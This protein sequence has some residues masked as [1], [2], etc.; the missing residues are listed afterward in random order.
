MNEN[1]TTS[2]RSIVRNGIYSFS[3][4]FLPLALSFFATPIIVRLLGNEDYGIYALILGFI[5][6]SFNF[7]VGR[8]ITKY[9]AEYR[10]GDRN[11]EIGDVIASTFFINIALGLFGLILITLSANFLVDD[12]L[13]IQP[14]N[15]DKTVYALYIASL[16]IF[17][18][19]LNQVFSAIL[20][21]LLR[22][23]VYAKIFNLN[24]ILLISG[25]IALALKGFGLLS[26]LTWNLSVT[27][28]SS[29]LSFI[30][31]KK[32]LPQ[33]TLRIG[34]SR[35]KLKLVFRFS[36]GVI[37]Y[38]ILANILLLFERSWITGKLGAENLTLYVVPMML[39]LYIHG[40]ISSLTMMLIPLASELGGENEKLLRLYKKATKIVCFFAFFI[41]ST[42]IVESRS[43]LTLWMG[44]DFADKSAQLLILHTITFSLLAITIVAWQL[45]EGLGYPKINTLFFVICFIVSVT[46]MIVLLPDFGSFG[47]AL[48][49][50]LGFSTLI[51]LIFYVEHRFLGE[52]QIKFWIVMI[53]RLAFAAF[54]SIVIELILRNFLSLS[55]IS[56]ILSTMIAGIVYCVTTWLIGFVTEEELGIFKKVFNR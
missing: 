41:G 51:S 24:N 29:L 54:F 43:F 31:A 21:G 50:T 13:K 8:A 16:T 47:V 15:H 55:W 30:S 3:T 1:T 34:F 46:G 22:Y 33:G 7:N 25:N 4:W 45:A 17:F 28:L 10:S 39:A 32:L 56:L 11:D 9:I 37:L 12:V 53:G 48:A 42:M 14:E 49:R 40:F 27:A 6:Y 52:I 44:A 23:D 36:S 26:L 38:Q 5:S 20:Q 2:S 19:M 35:E 18:L